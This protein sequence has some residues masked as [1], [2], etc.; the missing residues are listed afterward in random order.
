[1]TLVFQLFASH[2]G[3]QE[4]SAW[5]FLPARARVNLQKSLS[6][7]SPC[8]PKAGYF[9]IKTQRLTVQKS[10]T[11]EA[12]V[13]DL[14]RVIHW[15]TDT[16][17]K[18]IYEKVWAT[19]SKYEQ[20]WIA[21]H[22]FR[23]FATWFRDTRRSQSAKQAKKFDGTGSSICHAIPISKLSPTTAS[24]SKAVTSSLFGQERLGEKGGAFLKG[25]E[26]RDGPP[27]FFLPS[28]NEANSTLL[29]KIVYV[30]SRNITVFEIILLSSLP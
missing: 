12:K 10:V 15:L 3:R 19:M 29:P 28:G 26:G 6:P 13:R 24:Y 17:T 27:L 20:L 30:F 4:L 2:A 9:R 7:V 11:Y 25:K 8:H 16:R 5:F 21:P 23:I 1:M 18:K 22:H 14:R